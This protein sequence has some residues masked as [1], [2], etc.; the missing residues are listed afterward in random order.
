MEIT[1]TET[2]KPLTTLPP[3]PQL[4]AERPLPERQCGGVR[5]GTQALATH[6]T[7][8]LGGNYL[9]FLSF[10]FSDV[11][12]DD[13]R[14]LTVIQHR[15]N[16]VKCLVLCPVHNKYSVNNN[17][18]LFLGFLW[19][20]LFCCCVHFLTAAVVD[21][22]LICQDADSIN[23]WSDAHYN[24][25]LQPCPLRILSS[26]WTRERAADVFSTKPVPFTYLTLSLGVLWPLTPYK[27]I[28]VLSSGKQGNLKIGRLLP[29]LVVSNCPI[30]ISS[31]SVLVMED[32]NVF[33]Y[34][35]QG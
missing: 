19:A 33:I 15:L 16:G 26:P 21:S 30:P 7:G 8:W 35:S 34:T 14:P 29:S 13:K 25:S 20:L 12:G 11:K 10:A 1:H 3:M 23:P 17:Y 32:L 22:L 9:T 4:S 5:L 24:D 27:S 18:D 31:F 6:G 28:V 2:H